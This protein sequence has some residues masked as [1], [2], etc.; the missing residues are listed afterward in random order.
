MA[1]PRGGG[2][3]RRGRYSPSSGWELIRE[4]EVV[5]SDVWLDERPR[6]IDVSLEHR[7]EGIWKLIKRKPA[8]FFDFVRLAVR[9]ICWVDLYG[10][11][12]GYPVGLLVLMVA[13]DVVCAGED[14]VFWRCT[15]FFFD[16]TMERFFE[17]F[18]V[19]Q[20]APAAVPFA[21]FVSAVCGAF[22][23]E[24]VA[25]AVVAHKYDGDADVVYSYF[26]IMHQM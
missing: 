3:F 23:H 24:D 8:Q 10:V 15:V 14:D 26:H 22:V 18:A 1:V 7:V 6:E 16:F 21:D 19:L 12:E 9:D 17:G 5:L 2:S 13:Q 11:R 20:S 4:G 25:L